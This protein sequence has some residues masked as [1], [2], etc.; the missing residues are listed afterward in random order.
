MPAQDFALRY[1]VCMNTLVPTP[2][3]DKNGRLTTRHMKPEAVSAST[4]LSAPTPSLGASG[5][6]QM[7]DKEFL[8]Y[9]DPKN[10]EYQQHGEYVDA[11]HSIVEHSP[12]VIEDVTVLLELGN[13]AG[14]EAIRDFVGENLDTIVYQTTQRK[15]VSSRVDGFEDSNTLKEALAIHWSVASLSSE[16]RECFFYSLS[17]GVRKTLEVHK[18]IKPK[19]SEREYDDDLPYWRAVGATA[20]LA[21][22]RGED[23]TD[24]EVKNLQE[25]VQ[26]METK[27][28]LGDIIRVGVERGLKDAESIRAILESDAPTSLSSGAL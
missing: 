16:A 13:E 22:P 6:R 4:S 15:V 18:G 7:G 17:S 1:S 27:D 26:W 24:E 28:Y 21:N 19:S 25:L 11:L 14:S 5:V 9:V 3:I 23:L 12:T 20:I 10:K 2:R 8:T